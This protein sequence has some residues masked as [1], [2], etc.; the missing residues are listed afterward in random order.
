MRASTHLRHLERTVHDALE[1]FEL[2]GGGR[3]Y[4]DRN[5]AGAALFSY[6]I[7][8]LGVEEGDYGPEPPQILQRIWQ[9]RDPKAVLQRFAPSAPDRGFLSMADLPAEPGE[10]PPVAPRLG[11]DGFSKGF[12]PRP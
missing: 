4:Y 2:V 11:Q 8:L 6:M 9:S 1:S 7:A 5:Q 10:A 12:R 3:H